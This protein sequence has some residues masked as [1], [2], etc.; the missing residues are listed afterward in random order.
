MIW[1]S[2]SE[3]ER[4]VDSSSEMYQLSLDGQEMQWW[5][6]K[7]FYFYHLKNIIL[8]LY[9][10][11]SCHVKIILLGYKYKENLTN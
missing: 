2:N 3:Q 10:A 8:N 7:D 1:E 6:S 4:D 9:H 11:P 5:K